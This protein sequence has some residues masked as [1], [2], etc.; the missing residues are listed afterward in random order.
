MAA[1]QVVPVIQ[2]WNIQFSIGNITGTRVYVDAAARTDLVSV[3]LPNLYDS[4]DANHPTLKL[5]TIDVK[6]LNDGGCSYKVYTLSYSANAISSVAPDTEEES[7]PTTVNQSAE[8]QTFSDNKASTGNH[9]VWPDGDRALDLKIRKREITTTFN[10]H[11]RFVDSDLGAFIKASSE[12]LGKVNDGTFFFIPS[13]LCLYTGANLT[14][15]R[16]ASGDNQWDAT[17]S[18]V[19]KDIDGQWQANNG[20]QKVFRVETNQYEEPTNNGDKLYDTTTFT[21]LLEIGSAPSEG[22]FPEIPDE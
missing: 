11:R 10:I 12:R 9:W 6:Y 4:W 1:P 15:S 20:W 8:Y 7:F 22:D 5:R 14:Q 2:S 21:S 19:I 18:F 17:L 3:D 13:E 16:D